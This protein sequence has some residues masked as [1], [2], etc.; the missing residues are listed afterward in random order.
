MDHAA[1]DALL[2]DLIATWENEVVECTHARLLTEI[3]KIFGRAKQP[4]ILPKITQKNPAIADRGIKEKT[5]Q[6]PQQHQRRIQRIQ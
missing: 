3:C 4:K 5:P 6:H 2:T 1:L